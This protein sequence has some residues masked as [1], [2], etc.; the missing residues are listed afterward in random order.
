MTLQDILNSNLSDKH[1]LELI[2]FMQKGGL[3]PDQEESKK[4]ENNKTITPTETITIGDQEYD[5]AVADTPESRKEG[6]DPYGYLRPDE[7]MLFIFEEETTD[8]FTMKNCAIDLDIVFIDSEGEVI[9]VSS[10]KAYDPKPVV[11]EEP[12]QFVL[13]VNINSGIE[14]E[15]ELEQEDDSLSEEEKQFAGQ[16]NKMLVLDANGDVQMKLS[17]GERIFS[18]ICTRKM[19]KAAIQAYRQDTD[20]AYRKV[21]RLVLKELD[22]QDQRTPEFT[23]LES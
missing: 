3:T 10:V 2:T 19:I 6:L 22:F 23:Q 13:E 21:G 17:G 7:G 14:V 20:L 11:C 8:Y 1:K 12:Y 16:R 9:Q 18:R 5:V 15:D 4:S